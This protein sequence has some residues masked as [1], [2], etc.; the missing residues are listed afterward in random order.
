MW[1]YI[2]LVIGI[3]MGVGAALVPDLSMGFRD[4]IL[5]L[6]TFLMGVGIGGQFEEV[7]R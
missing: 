4:S 2:S 3:V 1:K 5:M 7:L 6:S